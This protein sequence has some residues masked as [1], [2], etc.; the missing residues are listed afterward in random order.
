MYLYARMCKHLNACNE[1]KF[2]RIEICYA[3]IM[4]DCI[5]CK[6]R[7]K[8]IPSDI[9]FEDEDVLVF[10]DIQPKAPLHL[11][12]VPKRHVESILILDDSTKEIPGM[13]IWRAKEFAQKKGIPG[14]K[15]TFHV[16]R[17]GGQIVDHLHLHLMANK[18]LGK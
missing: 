6:I 11:L 17:E 5:F 7:D 1:G 12:I 8:E 9:L 16:G 13:L 10:R 15:L 18:K 3:S 4:S 14:Y 2:C